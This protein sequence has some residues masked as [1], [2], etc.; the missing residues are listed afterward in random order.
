MADDDRELSADA[1]TEA[2]RTFVDRGQAA[3]RAVDRAIDDPRTDADKKLALA[4]MDEPDPEA[5]ARLMFAYYHD[6]GRADRTPRST[7]YLHM[8]LL[9]GAIMRLARTIRG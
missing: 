5:L 6:N 7:M 1:A 8:G 4:L 2:L 9:T 3:Q